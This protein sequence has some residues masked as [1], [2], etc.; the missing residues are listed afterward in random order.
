[1]WPAG[2][3][4]ALSRS[5]TLCCGIS[6]SS[7]RPGR[8]TPA[9]PLFPEREFVDAGGFLSYRP[10]VPA[11]FH[12]AATYVDKLLKGAKPADLPVEQP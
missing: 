4:D 1:M 7:R 9:A 10:S 6:A 8:Q 11:S 3:A 12:R 2:R 5:P